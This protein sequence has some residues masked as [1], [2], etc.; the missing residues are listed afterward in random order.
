[1]LWCG[2]CSRMACQK[3]SSYWW[4]WP[5][6]G[7]LARKCFVPPQYRHNPLLW[8]PRYPSRLKQVWHSC[9]L[10]KARWK[11]FHNEP[12]FGGSGLG[13]SASASS[14]DQ[15][16]AL[17][18][19]NLVVWCSYSLARDDQRH[20]WPLG[21]KLVGCFFFFW[22]CGWSWP[23]MPSHKPSSIAG[24]IMARVYCVEDWRKGTQEQ[25]EK[26]RQKY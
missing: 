4:A 19:Q 13:R 15:L 25:T 21:L 8:R 24:S 11:I 23:A 22:G 3:D 17:S 5:F 7:Q 10:I 14:C 2:S 12:V 6:T 16:S 26:A 1:M 20:G 9:Q 18:I